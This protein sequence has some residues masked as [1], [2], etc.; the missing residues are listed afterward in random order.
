MA[1]WVVLRGDEDHRIRLARGVRI[2]RDAE[3]TGPVDFGPDVF[4]NRGAYVQGHT[5]IGDRTS[6]GQFVRIVTDTHELGDHHQRAGEKIVRDVVIG[7]GVWIG[8]S[9]TILP[10]V[11]IGDG[12][13]V[14][15]G[16]VVTAD[17]EADTLVGG[18]PARLIRRLD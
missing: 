17:V 15:A 14:A 9:V 18:V 13:V 3:I 7:S 2:Y 10:G 1:P 4:L 11:R 12:A 6:V 5:T 8:A 16:S